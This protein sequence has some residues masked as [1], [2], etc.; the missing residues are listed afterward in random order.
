[1]TYKDIVLLGWVLE[2]PQHSRSFLS[3]HTP[4]K[5]YN[6]IKL[7]AYEN[8]WVI[9]AFGK[10]YVDDGNEDARIFWGKLESIEDLKTVMRLCNILQP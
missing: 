9:D 4:D 1:M 10:S 8:A 2:N 7:L 5:D 3:F 6:L